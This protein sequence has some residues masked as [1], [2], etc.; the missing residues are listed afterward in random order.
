MA[1]VSYEDGG[2]PSLTTPL[3]LSI[4]IPTNSPGQG[5]AATSYATLP[6]LPQTLD[7]RPHVAPEGE[8]NDES[9][10]LS[11]FRARPSV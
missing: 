6:H 5:G 9:W 1:A 4:V 3:C 2:S 11:V 10:G 7:D 8:R